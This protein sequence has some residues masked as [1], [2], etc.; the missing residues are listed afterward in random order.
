M[1]SS[2]LDSRYCKNSLLRHKCKRYQRG[3]NNVIAL[4]NSMNDP[5]VT[6]VGLTFIEIN[7]ED[8]QSPIKLFSLII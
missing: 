1:T 5:N 6:L 2:Y 8:S 7:V 4:T 3:A